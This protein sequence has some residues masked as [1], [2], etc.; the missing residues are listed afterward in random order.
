MKR[1]IICLLSVFLF[2]GCQC[3]L[4]THYF[5]DSGICICGYDKAIELTYNNTTNLYNATKHNVEERQI[6]YYKITTHG[7]DGLDF[8]LTSEDTDEEI[9]FDRIEIRGPGIVA[10]HVAGNKYSANVGKVYTNTWKYENNKEYRLKIWYYG[11]GNVQLQI[12]EKTN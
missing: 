3:S 6:Y 5:S 7:E 10:N 12:R 1:L 2:T 8:I 9:K 4:H 11:T